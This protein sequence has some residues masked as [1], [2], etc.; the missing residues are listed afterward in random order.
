[1]TY[2][3]THKTAPRLSLGPV[4]DTPKGMPSE[5]DLA[6]LMLRAA[7]GE[8]KAASARDYGNQTRHGYKAGGVP[9]NRLE[10]NQIACEKARLE[11]EAKILDYL[12]NNPESRNVDIA[13][14]LGK[15]PDT[16]QPH[17]NRMRMR[18]KIAIRSRL[19][20]SVVEGK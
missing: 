17:V 7:A 9:T 11:M 16:V 5:D 15:S 2:W 18:G 8:L 1:M 13:R 20:Y 19:Y 6:A 4:P 14:G 12:S 3:T 10:A